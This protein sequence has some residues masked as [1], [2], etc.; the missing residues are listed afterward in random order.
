MVSGMLKILIVEDGMDD[1]ELI[2]RALQ[3]GGVLFEVR[4]VDCSEKFLYTLR[5]FA[6]NVILSDHSLPQFNSIEALRIC[7]SERLKIPFILVTGS[8]SDQFAD[9]LVE[10]GASGYLLKSNLERLPNLIFKVLN[11]LAR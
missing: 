3:K 6:P 5:E 2:K 4:V 8:V 11:L 9:K 10:I 7:Q 1:V